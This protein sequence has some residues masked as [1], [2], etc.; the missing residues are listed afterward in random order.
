MVLKWDCMPKQ[1]QMEGVLCAKDEF[2]FS[3]KHEVV[4][5]ES[6]CALPVYTVLKKDVFNWDDFDLRFLKEFQM[7]PPLKTVFVKSTDEVVRD[8][9]LERFTW[10]LFRECEGVSEKSAWS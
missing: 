3:P 5:S 2:K 9:V 10:P 7:G 1:E 4:L 6:M 8:I